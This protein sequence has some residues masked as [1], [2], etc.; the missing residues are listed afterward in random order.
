MLLLIVRLSKQGNVTQFKKLGF[1]LPKK[2]PIDHKSYSTNQ[3]IRNRHQIDD[4]IINTFGSR[5]SFF[6]FQYGT[7]HGALCVGFHKDEKHDKKKKHFL[8]HVMRNKVKS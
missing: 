1:C 7:A 8:F 2:L 5:L 3:Y 6:T 4:P